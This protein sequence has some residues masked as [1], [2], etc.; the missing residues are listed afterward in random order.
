MTYSLFCTDAPT[1][2]EK[3]P[4]DCRVVPVNSDSMGAAIKEACRLIADGIIV[5]K[6]KGSDGFIMERSDIET[7]CLRRQ[8]AARASLRASALP[9]RRCPRGGC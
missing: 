3:M 2:S 1:P 7:E 9:P 8:G 6:I 5:W 4:D